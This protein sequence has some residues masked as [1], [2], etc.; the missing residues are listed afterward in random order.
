MVRILYLLLIPF[1]AMAGDFTGL[2]NRNPTNMGEGFTLSLTLTNSQPKGAPSLEAVR[3]LFIIHSQQQSYSTIMQN[4]KTTI[5]TIWHLTLIPQKPG[6][7][8]IPPISIATDKGIL[9]TDP[10]VLQVL[11]EHAK[12]EQDVSLVTTVSSNKP[13]KNETILYTVRLVSPHNLNNISLETIAVED[14]IVEHAEKPKIEKETVNGVKRNVVEFNYLITPLKPGAMVIPAFA[15][16]GEIP[17]RSKGGHRDLFSMLQGFDEVKPFVLNTDRIQMEV[18]PPEDGITPWLPA[19]S[20]VIKEHLSSTPMQALEPI[21]RNFEI[22]GEGVLAAQLPDL[23]DQQT[24]KSFRTYS[25]KPELK[26]EFLNGKILSTRK[27]SYTLI[28]QTDGE[29]TLPGISIEWWDVKNNKKIITSIAPRTVHV[30]PQA[31]TPTSPQVM[32]AQVVAPAPVEPPNPI[33][34]IV[35]GILGSLLFITVI[36]L[37]VM[38]RQIAKM[39]APPIKKVPVNPMVVVPPP[40]VKKDKKEKLP[41]LNPT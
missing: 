31:R 19:E 2:V 37:I 32:E 28:P 17:L 20:V 16:Q 9:S 15:L 8:I 21:T 36:G 22:R 4:G 7:L 29:L 13:Y 24:T 27:E 39:K 14:A 1:I 38:S 40:K 3:E 25:D 34:Y 30:L 12:D 11:A 23:T 5:S 33:L 18:S 10:I 26:N 35:I 6:K 41:D